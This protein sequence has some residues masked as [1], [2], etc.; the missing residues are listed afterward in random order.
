MPR[1]SKALISEGFFDF[2][3]RAREG[4]CWVKGC[5]N[6]SRP[7]RSL[8]RKHDMR[9]WRAQKKKT[10]DYCT[11]RDHANARGIEFKIT[12]DYWRG[13]VDAF[14]Y[15]QCGP[16]E[17]MTIDRVEAHKGYV[18]GNLRVVTLSLNSVKANRERFLPEHVQNML[19]R[20]RGKMQKEKKKYLD[21]DHSDPEPEPPQQE[22]PEDD[23]FEGDPPF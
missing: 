8:C 6:D 14:G 20:N 21:L 17:V 5:Q 12:L 4:A 16:D 15:Y 7:D 22:A 1:P 3:K 13:I 19:E 10:A 11:L 9:R 18:E 23:F 2:K